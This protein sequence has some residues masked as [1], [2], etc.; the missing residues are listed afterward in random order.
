MDKLERINYLIDRLQL[1]AHP[2]GGYYNELYRSEEIIE[3]SSGKRNGCTSIYFLL[4]SNEVSKFHQ[5]KS[6]EIWYHH[7][8][9][10]LVIDLLNENGHEI[11]ALGTVSDSFVPQQLVKK[12]TIFGAR[13]LE[14][15][16]YALVSCVVS[17]G[18]DFSDFILFSK[19]ELL[20]QFPNEPEII[21][22][23]T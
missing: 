6:D 14:K 10:A 12:N 18:F 3:T 7:E 19:E 13:V 22:L 23:L 16:S 4:P 5:I 2:E 21:Q 20:S 15:D 9:S 1:K 11:L 8:G 17:P